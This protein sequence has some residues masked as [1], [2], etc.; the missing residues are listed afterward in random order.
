MRAAVESRAW[1][2]D[3]P[4]ASGPAIFGSYQAAKHSQFQQGARFAAEGI[5]ANPKSFLLRNNLA[6]CLA[7]QG[8]LPGAEADLP[9]IHNE[10]LDDD[11]RATIEATRGLIAFRAGK[12]AE[13]VD[14]YRRAMDAFTSQESKV[15]ALINFAVETLRVN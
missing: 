8:D 3:Q 6:F 2:Y 12:L 14:R 4:F 15:L 7:K 10:Q 5:V 11:E 9:S 13:G 1:F